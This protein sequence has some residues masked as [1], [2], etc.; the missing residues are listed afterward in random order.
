MLK[1]SEAHQELVDNLKDAHQ[2]EITHVHLQCA[3]DTAKQVHT[4]YQV[5]TRKS[6][7]NCLK[8]I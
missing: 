8:F 3:S 6:L 7:C 5:I 2:R 1:A 4:F